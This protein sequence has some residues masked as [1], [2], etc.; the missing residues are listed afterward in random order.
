M[1]YDG[2]STRAL[3]ELNSGP[4]DVSLRY[5]CI[6]GTYL[7][8]KYAHSLFSSFAWSLRCFHGGVGCG[9]RSGALSHRLT[10]IYGFVMSGKH[11]GFNVL[12]RRK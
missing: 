10:I 8:A 3:R 2:T 1:R 6:G 7:V 9:Q 12:Y 11:L 5:V 4:V